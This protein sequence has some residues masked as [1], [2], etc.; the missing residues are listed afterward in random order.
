LN[1]SIY[2]YIYVK[3]PT[4]KFLPR[5]PKI[6]GTAL[7]GGEWDVVVAL[8]FRGLGQSGSVLERNGESGME[9]FRPTCKESGGTYTSIDDNSLGNGMGGHG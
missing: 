4:Y 1:L 2:I 3:G 8:L 7:E 5:A 6:S 9:K